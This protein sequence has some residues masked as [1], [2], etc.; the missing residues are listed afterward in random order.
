MTR[1]SVPGKL[2]L[3]GEYAVLL[4]GHDCLVAAV[5][6][7]LCV[8][9]EAAARWSV[10]SGEARW[11]QG[12]PVPE[13]LQFAVA[14]ALAVE[15]RFAGRPRAL[16]TRDELSV[17]GH[18][19]G[20]GGSAAATVAAAFAAA[21]GTGAAREA[22]WA[23]ADEV[24]RRVQ[25]GRGSGADV[26]ASVFGGVLRYAKE[27]RRA[28]PAAVHPDVRL[29]AVWTGASVKTA[30]RLARFQAFV[31]ERPADAQRFAAASDEAV[32]AL[33]LGLSQGSAKGL[34]AALGAA[35]EA[36][37]TLE[38]ACGLELETPALRLAV[39]VAQRLGAAGK[40]SGAGG[41]DCAVVLAVGDEVLRRVVDG[42]SSAG[43]EP[44][45]LAFAK[46]GVRVERG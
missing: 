4:P 5:E 39:E 37:G 44:F 41:G 33:A 1:V 45:P 22:L 15:A 42:L 29:V 3:A 17:D 32:E 28:Q 7:R 31:Q 46:E 13:G 35:R 8:E 40:L 9:A 12:E 43:L 11:T 27:P 21:E 6:R 20:L 25:G 36:L 18:K 38:E 23:L 19:L 16:Q 30:P 26:A 10:R 24:H 34:R 14:A 2:L